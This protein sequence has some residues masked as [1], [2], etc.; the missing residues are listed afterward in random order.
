MIMGKRGE[1]LSLCLSADD[2]YRE[3][4]RAKYLLGQWCL[5]LSTC[6]DFTMLPWR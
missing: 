5:I 1:G 4:M 2:I 6:V 3:A